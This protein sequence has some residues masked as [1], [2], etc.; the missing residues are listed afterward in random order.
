MDKESSAPSSSDE[1]MATT[2]RARVL[3]R[4]G[5]ARVRELVNMSESVPA[6]AERLSALEVKSVT[7]KTLEV[8]A[9]S[10]REFCDWSGLSAGSNVEALEASRVVH[11]PTIFKGPSA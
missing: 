3:Q 11:E 4:F 8:Y 9:T 5:R 1:V 10:V 2:G 6:E 7:R